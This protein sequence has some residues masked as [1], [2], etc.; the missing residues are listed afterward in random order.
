VERERRE[1]GIVIMWVDRDHEHFK[2]LIIWTLI[3]MYAYLLKT[4]GIMGNFP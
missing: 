1:R 3:T 2:S 4:R